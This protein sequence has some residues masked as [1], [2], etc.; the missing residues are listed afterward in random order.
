MA[1]I[2]GTLPTET[3]RHWLGA[4][5]AHVSPTARRRAALESGEGLRRLASLLPA[6][7]ECVTAILRPSLGFMQVDCCL[8]GPD[9]VLVVETL[10]WAGKIAAGERG[11][12]L[13]AGSVDLGRPDRRAF[14]LADRLA[15][16]GHARGFRVEPVVICTDGP[17]E[18]VGPPPLTRVVP[19]AEAP[20]FLA[21]CFARTEGAG[22]D[23]TALIGLL[24]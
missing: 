7:P 13:G 15:Y 17:V 4:L 12:W 23:L 11:E 8:L 22:G 24:T 19:W 6:L 18:F 3:R 2:I 1:K 10:H 20:E 14:V 16:S 21:E 5:A 9:R